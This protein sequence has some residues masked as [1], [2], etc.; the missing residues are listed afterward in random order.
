LSL[1]DRKPGEDGRW[2]RGPRGRHLRRPGR[3]QDTGRRR[4]G[5]RTI[6]ASDCKEIL[7][8]RMRGPRDRA[9]T[10]IRV[11]PPLTA[12]R[13]ADDRRDDRPCPHP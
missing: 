2:R 11:F 13:H 6:A 1:H 3:R 7:P 4:N 12:P 8:I 9:F 5:G 10:T